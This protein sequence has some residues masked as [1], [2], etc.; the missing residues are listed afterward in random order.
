MNLVEV[1]A[2]SRHSACIAE[3]RPADALS[4]ERIDEKLSVMLSLGGLPTG[5]STA[6][7]PGA[8]NTWHTRRDLLFSASHNRPH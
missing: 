5:A 6:S 8:E 4:F 3:I 1:R 2:L 7:V